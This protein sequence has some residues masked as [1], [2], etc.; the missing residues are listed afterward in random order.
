[1]LSSST[2]MTVVIVIAVLVYFVVRQFQE[3][4]LSARTLL[5]QPVLFTIYSFETL[6]DQFT[7]PL[8]SVD[9]LIALMV[10]GV[11]TGS[12]L[13]WYRAGLTR[14]RYDQESGKIKVKARGLNI[15]LYLLVLI[16]RFGVEI[17]VGMKLNHTNMVV[18]LLAAFLA[19]FFLFNIYLEKLRLYQR[20][21]QY[22][23]SSMDEGTS[24]TN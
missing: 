3:Q 1:M 8:V 14:M 23:R 6:S 10:I 17:M 11:V 21:S 18:A 5:L 22:S 12:A 19:T 20:S 15:V 4:V 2:M 24:F 7:H 16:A 9:I 13:G